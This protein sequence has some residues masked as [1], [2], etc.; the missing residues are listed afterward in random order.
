MALTRT[1]YAQTEYNIVQHLFDFVLIIN[2]MCMTLTCLDVVKKKNHRC[3]LDLM[4]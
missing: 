3:H 4:I 2:L 1:A